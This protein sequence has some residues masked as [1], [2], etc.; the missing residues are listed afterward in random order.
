M[1]ETK[2]PGRPGGLADVG[3][4]CVGKEITERDLEVMKHMARYRVASMLSLRG[5]VFRGAGANT[6][7]K[8]TRR[9][10]RNGWVLRHQLGPQVCV[11][12]LSPKAC[13]L[14]G[15]AARS[16]SPR[17]QARAHS[18]RLRFHE[19]LLSGEPGQGTADPRRVARGFPA[20]VGGR[21]GLG[22]VLPRQRVSAAKER[23]HLDR[24]VRGSSTVRGG[25]PGGVG[26][27]VQA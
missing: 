5:A 23:T 27:A 10:V 15:G 26:G 2:L 19:L 20:V 4:M 17:R 14:M 8:V 21:H 6:A 25:M 1:K 9:L 13:C 3:Q 22:S 12:T 18:V 7:G 11:L 16:G 24:R